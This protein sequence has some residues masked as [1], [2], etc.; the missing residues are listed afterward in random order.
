MGRKL[1]NKLPKIQVNP[2]KSYSGK[3]KFVREMREERDTRKSMPIRRGV[4]WS[5]IL[6]LAIELFS[7]KARETN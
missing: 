4:Q 5:A 2:W 1:R 3:Y 7:A 6:E